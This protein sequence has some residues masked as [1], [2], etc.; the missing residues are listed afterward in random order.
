MTDPMTAYL[1]AGAEELAGTRLL[2]FHHAGGGASTFQEWQQELGPGVAVLPVLLPGRERRAGEQRFTRMDALVADLDRSLGPLLDE[3]PY[4]FYGHSMGAI[5]AY[6]LTL[7]RAARGRSLPFRLMV[8]A[9]PPPHLLAPITEALELTDDQLA[10]WMV[11]IG[12]M[13]EVVLAYPDWVKA[14]LDLLR[15][16]LL[17]CQSH[18]L[19]GDRPLACP[20]DVFAGADD[21][22]LP[23]ARV[24]GW[25]EHSTVNC[26][27]HTMPGG[28]FFIQESSFVFLRTLASLLSRRPSH[29]LGAG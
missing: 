23:L 11:D 15:D 2:C 13:S 16:D 7:R 29:Y 12:G 14:A 5:V 22:L 9:Y 25:A 10:R 28:H 27:L 8:G 26:R 3:A 4:A 17:V 19:P 20:I 18:E 6:N 21:P 1:P 24:S